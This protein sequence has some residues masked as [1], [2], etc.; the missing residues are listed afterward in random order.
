M[1]KK[2]ELTF[3]RFHINN[4]KIPDEVWLLKPKSFIKNKIKKL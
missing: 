2:K 4:P 1:K 3:I